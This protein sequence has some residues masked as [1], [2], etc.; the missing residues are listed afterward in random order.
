[1]NIHH[2]LTGIATDIMTIHGVYLNINDVYKYRAFMSIHDV[3]LD[4]QNL[5]RM[6][7]DIV[8]IHD[9]YSHVNDVYIHREYS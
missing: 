7:I 6:S 8:T 9:D 2:F 4:L 5:I 3:F 1:M